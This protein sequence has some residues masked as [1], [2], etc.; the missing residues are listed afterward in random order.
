MIVFVT[1]ATGVLG[2]P[3]VKR[4][5]RNGHEVRALSRSA[6]NREQLL[7]AGAIPASVDLYDPVSVAMVMRG[8]D[9]VLHLATRIPRV[10]EMKTPGVWD[11][12]DRIRTEGMRSL[13]E[14]AET[15]SSV[16]TFV[17]PSI[18]LF[19]GD[20]GDDWITAETATVEPCAFHLSTLTAENAV[21][22]FAD[23]A[24]GRKG[25]I[26]RFGTFY[27]PSSPDSL[28]T[29]MMAHRGVAMPVSGADAYKSMIWID[30]A[31]RAV[32]DALERAPGGTFDVVE[33]L[34]STQREALEA[35]AIAVDRKRLVKLPR[36]L[37]RKA[38]PAD[39]RAMLARSQRIS[40]ARF[41][42]ATGWHPEITSQ[43]IGWRLM[44]D[45]A[46]ADSASPLS[47]RPKGRSE[48]ASAA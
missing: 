12:N 8:C 13:I 28:Q 14:A 3:V 7:V 5:V 46:A 15:V 47:G 24:P 4:L 1:G 42:E 25:I 38:L 30:D 29:I 17:Y 48:T 10:S 39:L 21:R 32:I 23:T 22:R 16:R 31:A 43:R 33:D 27:G 40:N 36:V 11:E 35:L 20:G 2:A 9:A 34:P 6:A 45:R 37:L 19:Y 18:S 44:R 26:L 41:R